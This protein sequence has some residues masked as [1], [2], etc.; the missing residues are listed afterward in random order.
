MYG[1]KE[2]CVAVNMS[3]ETLKFY[4]NQGLVP[5][6]KRDGSNRRIFDEQD[7]AWLKSLS[8]LKK[9]G[10]SIQEMKTYQDLCLQGESS[11]P[12]RK[13]ILEH[14]REELLER[15]RELE[16]S[17]AYIDRKQQFYDDVL[18]GNREYTSNLLPKMR[19]S[20]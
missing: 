8:C 1:M 20:V 18:A 5:N 6:L 9:C 4:C 7:I 10:M 13:R 12:Q 14:K 15:R 11:I 16:E 3:Y 17:M 19:E 2:A